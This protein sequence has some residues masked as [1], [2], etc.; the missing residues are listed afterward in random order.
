MADNRWIKLRTEMFDDDKIKIIQAMP[1]GDSLIV[2]WIRMLI[3]AEASNAEGCL[4]I[5]DSLPYSEEMLATVFNKSL[6][7]IRLA[8]KTFEAFGMVKVEN[9]G[10]RIQSFAEDQNEKSQDIR[11]YN[12]LKKAE[13]RKRAKQKCLGMSNPEEIDQESCVEDKLIT[14]QDYVIDQSRTSQEKCQ[15]Q[16]N[17]RSMTSQGQ[18]NDQEKEKAKEKE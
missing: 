18:V 16:V 9:G 10:I 15:G 11:E 3:L 12:R 13:S 8:V 7:V 2:I 6:S 4:M 14:S 5:S 17:D 1:E